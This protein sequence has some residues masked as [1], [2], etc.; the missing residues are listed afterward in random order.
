MAAFDLWAVSEAVATAAARLAGMGETYAYEPASPIT[1]CV[2][3]RWTRVPI[4]GETSGAGTIV[5][6]GELV[7][8]PGEMID[9]EAARTLYGWLSAGS[10]GIR[11]VMETADP[12]LGGVVSQ[13]LLTE[14]AEVGSVSSV[15]GERAGATVAFRVI[16]GRDA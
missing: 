11:A 3:V 15:Y 14:A 7:L 1:P 9:E 6:D 4:L 2:M 8:I 5:A 16:A 10:A 13:F 12:T